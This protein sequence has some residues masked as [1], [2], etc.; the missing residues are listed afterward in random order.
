MLFQKIELM[1]VWE[2]WFVEV[3]VRNPIFHNKVL[4]NAL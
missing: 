3:L 2:F 1:E 4:L